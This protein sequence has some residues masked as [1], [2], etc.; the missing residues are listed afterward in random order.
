MA[1]RRP[2]GRGARA[3]CDVEYCIGG[4]VG[5]RGKDAGPGAGRPAKRSGSTLARRE[6]AEVPQSH[7]AG[8]GPTAGGRRG[9]G[10]AAERAGGRGGGGDGGRRRGGAGGGVWGGRAPASFGSWTGTSKSSSMKSR[11]SR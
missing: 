3:G 2:T 7:G 4:E 9:L 8:A 11:R 10:G 6:A 5:S 1:R